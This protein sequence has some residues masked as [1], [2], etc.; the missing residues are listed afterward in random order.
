LTL[1]KILKSKIENEHKGT[2]IL[3]K[4]T[5]TL[6]NLIN[7]GLQNNKSIDFSGYKIDHLLVEE[8]E[9]KY[10]TDG[11]KGIKKILEESVNKQIEIFE[12]IIK[13]VK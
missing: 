9:I 2:I 11:K 5:F 12:K 6:A 4:E 10:I 3:E 13:M 7:D 1:E 8:S